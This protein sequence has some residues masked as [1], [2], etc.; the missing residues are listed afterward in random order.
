MFKVHFK[1]SNFLSIPDSSH[2]INIDSIFSYT[3]HFDLFQLNYMVLN[4]VWCNCVVFIQSYASLKEDKAKLDPNLKVP[5]LTRQ[6][7]APRVVNPTLTHLKG[8]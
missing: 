8:S 1:A 2:H 4:K 3:S 5:I 6:V 7:N